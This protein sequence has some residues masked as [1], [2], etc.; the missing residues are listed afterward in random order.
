MVRLAAGTKGLV[1][2]WTTVTVAVA[3]VAGCA[4]PADEDVETAATAFAD[5]ARGA[6]QGVGVDEAIRPMEGGVVRLDDRVNTVTDAGGAFAFDY[7][8]PGSVFLTVDVEGYVDAQTT[9]DVAAGQTSQVRITL[10]A[11]PVQ[12]PYLD[13][14]TWQGMMSCG[15]A[16]HDPV[17]GYQATSCNGLWRSVPGFPAGVDASGIAIRVGS[18]ADV[19][20]FWTELAWT[21]TTPAGE[22]MESNW[23]YSI[24]AERLNFKHVVTTAGPSVLAARIP[25]EALLGTLDD[26]PSAFCTPEDCEL[27]GI[28]TSSASLGADPLLVGAHANQP[29]RAFLTVFHHGTLPDSYSVGD[30]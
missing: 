10:A 5:G 15:I 14:Y 22:T 30:A 11:I 28:P 1:W 24:D 13:V 21:P 26:T 17:L 6:I 16:W 25:I 8:T 12:E 4:Q 23:G 19:V 3:L 27:F 29:F 18:L 7:V 2:T 9:V 20:G